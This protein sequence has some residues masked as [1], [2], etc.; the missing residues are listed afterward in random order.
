MRS[1]IGIALVWLV[2]CGPAGRPH[3]GDDDDGPSPDG[4]VV[5]CDGGSCAQDC[6]EGSKDL[7]YVLDNQN[8]LHS[9]DP[10]LLAQGTGAFTDLGE[11]DCPHSRWPIDGS[12]DDVTPMSMSVDRD[13]NAWVHYTSG[14]I[15]R[16]PIDHL[17]QCV[18][19]GYQPGQAGMDLF[20]M[21]FVTDPNAS[22]EHLYIA[23]GDITSVPGGDLAVIDPRGAPPTA[24]KL[25]RM[26]NDG[27][28]SPELTGTGG[29]ELWGFYPG[30]D[31]AWVQQIDRAS[32][33]PKGP[34]KDIPG[35]LGGLGATPSVV[36]WAFAQWDGT[37]YIFVTTT[38]GDPF[39][40]SST[41]RTIDPAGA[42]QVRLEELP[43]VIVG[44]GVSTCAPFV[45]Y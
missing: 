22:D 37:F 19:T 35:G 44:A 13:G 8:H 18:Q 31:E 17:D 30:I 1:R 42:Y 14:E 38:P 32:G 36:A 6:G 41:L 45:I 26:T 9:F 11:L 23:G 4:G 28:H 24:T 34:R 27:E 20:G 25:G 40:P 7:V 3:E 10:R 33:A 2:A 15:F 16:V 43:W 29:G 39:P 12:T 5:T 21:G